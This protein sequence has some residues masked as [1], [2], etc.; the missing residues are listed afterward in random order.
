[1]LSHKESSMM[2]EEKNENHPVDALL[3]KL[4]T[5]RPM[6]Q[7]DLQHASPLSAFGTIYRLMKLVESGR[8]RVTRQAPATTYRL[9]PA[10]D[11]KENENGD[12]E[13]SPSKSEDTNNVST[14]INAN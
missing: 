5:Q 12:G 7:A 1:M 11:E 4:V 2:D 13:T 3:M 14:S 9:A 8:L 10:K 6:S